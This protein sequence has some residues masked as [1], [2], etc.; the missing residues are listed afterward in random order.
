MTK[1]FLKHIWPSQGLYCIAVPQK[2]TTGKGFYYEHKVFTNIEEAAEAAEAIS[3]SGKDCYMAVGTLKDYKVFNKEDNKY[4]V[5]VHEN[6]GWFRSLIFDIDC[7][8]NHVYKTQKE[9]LIALKEFLASTGLDRPTVINSGGGLH[10]Y[11]TFEEDITAEEWY[12]ITLKLKVVAKHF[13]LDVDPKRTCDKSSVLRVEGTYNHKKEPRPVKVLGWGKTVA[14]K[15]ITK[16]LNW[17]IKTENITPE[18][19]PR[20]SLKDIFKIVSENTTDDMYELP[21]GAQ[22]IKKCNVM[23]QAV[24]V[25]GK[26]LSEPQWRDVL[27]ISGKC[28]VPMDLEVSDGH[29]GF[30]ESE[31]RAMASRL[32]QQKPFR[33]S[34]FRDDFPEWCKD[35]THN[36]RNPLVLGQVLKNLPPPSSTDEPVEVAEAKET[37]EVVESTSEAPF[38]E[39]SGPETIKTEFG[40]SIALPDPPYPYKRTKNGVFLETLDDEDG[41][42]ESTVIYPYDIYPYEIQADKINGMYVV[43]IK[44]MLPHEKLSTKFEMP[45]HAFTDSKMFGKMLA[46]RGVMPINNN[47]AEL[48]LIYMKSYINEIQK[49][50]KT[51]HKYS[52]LGWH[53][54]GEMFVLPTETF[55]DDGTKELSGVNKALTHTVS[56]F[57]KK[58]TME[59]WRAIIDVYA[60][61]GYEPYAFGHLVGYGSLLLRFTD[62]EGAIVSMVGK[63]G[64]GKSTILKTINS[65]FGHPTEPMLVQT[66]TYLARMDRLGVFNSICVTYDEITNIDPEELSDLCYSVTQGR[67]KHRLNQNAEAKENHTKWQMILACSSNE[68]LLGKLSSLKHDASA[69]S[70][71]VF[72]YRVDPMGVMT[73]KESSEIFD[74]L[75]HNF[76]HA[77]EPFI[78][79]VVQHPE[80]VQKLVSYYTSKFDEAADIPNV[81]RYWSVIV[82]CTL[83]GGHIANELNLAA[84]DMDKLFKWCVNQV[85]DMREIVVDNRRDPEALLVEYLNYHQTSTIIVSDSQFKSNGITIVKE[86][87]SSLLIRTDLT[88]NKAYID[89]MAIKQWLVKGGSDFHTVKTALKKEGIL[90]DE[91]ASKTLSAGSNE[92][93]SGQLRCWLVDLSH[94]KI[95]SYTPL[96]SVEKDEALD[97]GLDKAGDI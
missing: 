67:G 25:R 51:V 77:G 66:D 64:S 40:F 58:G 60:R 93:H 88:L 55:L 33:C 13:K 80:K 90:L 79:Y 97:L 38:E 20:E 52:Q 42:G 3:N 83:A 22:I 63:S 48:L 32:A 47:A 6:M 59:E 84:F 7:G 44:V 18:I 35:C 74:K 43:K 29:E 76:G 5:R 69:E 30:D 8:H 2:I 65:I 37:V 54:D 34:T 4:Q 23:K 95:A 92:V 19:S 53:E 17:I 72:E 86:P 36:V 16:H 46:D 26:G 75:K 78:N 39:G 71:R 62:Y 85:R 45:W 27:S 50:V 70:L 94:P 49:L 14:L 61:P 9:A 82:S 41:A 10:V 24:A 21:D 87:K 68:A 81:E 11:F 91:N 96:T 89:K 12:E 1:K 73:R 57:R 56:S 15:E 31:M 28:K